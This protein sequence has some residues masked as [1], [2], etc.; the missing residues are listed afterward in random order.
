[1]KKISFLILIVMSH[2]ISKGCLAQTPTADK[3]KIVVGLMVDQMRWDYLYKYQ[4]RYVDGGIKRLLAQGFRCENTMIR[5]VPTVT[6]AGHASVY[7]G[8][9]PALNGI[10]GNDWYDRSWGREISNV[11]D[12]TVTGVGGNPDLNRSPRNLLTTTIGDELRMATNYQSKVVGISIKDRGAILPGGHTANAAFW[13]KSGKFTTSTYYMD[14]LPDWVNAFNKKKWD[15]ILMPKDWQTLHPIDTYVLSDK[16][17]KDYESLSGD[18]KKPVFPHK[19]SISRSPFGN[20]WTLEFAKAAIDGYG[21]GQGKFTDFLAVSLSSPDK[22]GH[23]YGP[24]SIEVEDTY[25]RLDRDLENFFNYLDER[26]GKNGYLF[27]ITADHGGNHSPGY[28]EEH[29]IPTGVLTND[30]FKQLGQAL[31]KE[32]GTSD[33]ILAKSGFQLYLDYDVLAKIGVDK[34]TAANFIIDQLKQV[35]GIETAFINEDLASAA[36][37]EPVK[38]MLINGYNPKRSGDIVIVKSAGWKAGSRMGATHGDWNPYDSH[39]PLVWMGAG[40]RP[41]KTHRNIGMTDIAPTLAALLNIQQP[42]GCVGQVITE[43]TD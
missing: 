14:A 3:P 32:F 5:H 9:V 36:Y 18:E 40:I 22:I 2:F 7:T 12:S 19:T 4:D 43:I 20:T 41:G 11:E 1:M 42:S 24:N 16:D 17:D 23:A 27:F 10:V 8:S 31:K 29:R 21:L 33:I 30:V 37:P 34:T 6:A 25:L 15:K 28:L 38:T 35:P 39:I 13:E 26:Y